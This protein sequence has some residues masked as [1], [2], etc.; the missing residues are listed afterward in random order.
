MIHIPAKYYNW[1]CNV[2]LWGG[3]GSRAKN[4]VSYERKTPNALINHRFE[5]ALICNGFTTARI[6]IKIVSREFRLNH[7]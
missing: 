2:G 4:D 5:V 3:G 6:L 1:L 7:N